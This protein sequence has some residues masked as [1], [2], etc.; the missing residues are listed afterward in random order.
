MEV[1]EISSTSDSQD[2]TVEGSDAEYEDATHAKKRKRKVIVKSS[3]PSKKRAPSDED[4]EPKQTKDKKGKRPLKTSAASPSKGGPE[5]PLTV[6]SS[7]DE[8]HPVNEGW[9]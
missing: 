8:E 7:G 6:K 2:I 9:S 1:L 3:R 4:V 5:S